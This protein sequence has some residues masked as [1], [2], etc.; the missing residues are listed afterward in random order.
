M[1]IC[2]YSYNRSTYR[3]ISFLQFSFIT[4]SIVLNFLSLLVVF[5]LYLKLGL[6]RLHKSENW[7]RIYYLVYY[8]S[9]NYYYSILWYLRALVVWQLPTLGEKKLIWILKILVNFASIRI[10]Y[11]CQILYWH[12]LTKGRPPVTFK[13]Q[14]WMQWQWQWKNSGGAVV[15]TI[16]L[17]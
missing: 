10:S 1:Y 16:E 12:S 6:I 8:I 3:W 11:R 2:T 13:R 4:C 14:R 5:F 7:T 17:I 9:N 15:V